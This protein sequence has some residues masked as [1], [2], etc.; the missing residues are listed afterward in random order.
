MTLQSANIHNERTIDVRSSVNVDRTGICPL[1]LRR[2]RGRSRQ[3]VATH[4]E[5]C[6]VATKT[7]GGKFEFWGPSGNQL[8]KLQAERK[9]DLNVERFQRATTVASERLNPVTIISRNKSLLRLSELSASESTKYSISPKDFR[10]RKRR[11]E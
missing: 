4:D 8:N 7:D 5:V 11:R 2:C 3:K 1:F 10:R 9:I 6:G